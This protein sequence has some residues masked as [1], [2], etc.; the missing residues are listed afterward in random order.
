MSKIIKATVIANKMI[1][2]I[3]VN[4]DR[5]IKHPKYHKILKRRT[6]L[7]VHNDLGDIPLGSKVSIQ[8]TKPYS[9]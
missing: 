1:N 8:E 5:V 3:V 9:K 7:F 4:I 2:T 6:K